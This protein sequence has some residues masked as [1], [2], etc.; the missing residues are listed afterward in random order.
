MNLNSDPD[1]DDVV[2]RTIQKDPRLKAKYKNATGLTVALWLE[3][4]EK[5]GVD[6]FPEKFQAP[7]NVIPMD[8]ELVGAW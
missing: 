3:W 1:L 8:R 7:T 4:L 2:K 6:P 5:Q